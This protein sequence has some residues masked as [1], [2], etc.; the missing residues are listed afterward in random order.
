MKK[1][2]FSAG[3]CILYPEVIK[4]ASEAI[5]NFKE[6]DLSLLEISHRDKNFVDVMEEVR[7]LSKEIG[8]LQEHVHSSNVNV[9]D[10]VYHFFSQYI[11]LEYKCE[12]RDFIKLS[13]EIVEA[14]LDKPVCVLMFEF[15]V[16]RC[17]GS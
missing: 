4:G 15:S 13:K 8:V 9:N 12:P 10:M 1:H 11:D 3:P 2:N 7:E 6:L 17:M 16:N 14:T 5:N